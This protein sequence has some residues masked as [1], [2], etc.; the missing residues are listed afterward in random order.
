MARILQVQLQRIRHLSRTSLQ[1]RVVGSVFTTSLVMIVGLGLV[2]VWFVSQQ[3]IDTK[4]QIASNEIERAR[5][6]VEQQVEATDSS[7]SLQVR[8]NSARAALT[9]KTSSSTTGEAAAVY[10]PVVQVTNTD[11]SVV[12]SPEGYRIPETLR[13]V[14]AQQQV[15]Y[16]FTTVTRNDG[17]L[18][19]SLI[20]GSPT[21][22]DI[23]GLEVYLVLPLENEESTLSLI[24][25]LLAVGGLL[26]VGLLLAITFLLTRQIIQP[27]RS[28]SRIA[29]RLTAGHRKERMQVKGEDEMATLARSFNT[30]AESL[31]QQI[32]QLEEYGDLQRQFTSDVSHELRTPLTTVRMAADVIADNREELDP[33]TARASEL[34]IRE[35]DRFEALLGDLLEISRHDAGV[36]DLNEEQVDITTAIVSAFSQVQHL[37]KELG[38]PVYFALPSTPTVVRCDI[39]RIERIL[40]NL[41]AN[42][43]DQSEGHPILVR[44]AANDQAA[45]ITVSDNGVGLKPGQEALVFNRFWRADASRVRHSGG[46]GLGLSIA[47]N[48]ALL[49]G[50]TLDAKG[51]IGVGSTFRLIVPR[52]PAGHVDRD[53]LPLTLLP[54]F[55]DD[56]VEHYREGLE[57]GLLTTD[58]SW[59]I[60][61]Y[62][63][64]TGNPAL[65]AGTIAGQ[66]ADVTEDLQLDNQP[67]SAANTIADE[68][69]QL[70][71]A[72]DSNAAA[73][74]ER[75]RTNATAATANSPA[76]GIASTTTTSD[77]VPTTPAAAVVSTAP[78]EVAAPPEP[79][80]QPT[81]HNRGGEDTTQ[82]PVD[83]RQLYE[84][85]PAENSAENQHGYPAAF[86]TPAD[87]AT[88]QSDSGTTARE[89][90]RHI[91]EDEPVTE[92]ELAA[93]DDFDD[94]GDIADAD[95]AD[96]IAERSDQHRSPQQAAEQST[97]ATPPTGDHQ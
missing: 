57:A 3:L 61:N 87:L 6:T 88:P 29:Q 76:E 7:N 15:A 38:V 77:T 42:A 20:I 39:R 97:P 43:I 30:M 48:D 31:S 11:G 70:I 92:E 37:A 83:H 12:A 9:N 68:A 60:R 62:G 67:P 5:I 84:Q 95:D 50:G 89:A 59:R 16:Q 4:L 1:W 96:I 91:P 90:M 63:D 33:I 21:Q 18:A 13:E 74:A 47:H 69:E 40:R 17:S 71:D 56:S 41:L 32:Q 65:T 26:L 19:R 36:A 73:H 25:R 51:E 79:P 23:P 72:A 55:T 78:V 53:P 52:E 8:L 94:F 64:T 27:V 46:T 93:F 10:E 28:A 66:D 80:S 54:S 49:H 82:T 81:S 58:P 75:S 34:M 22:S 86:P 2:L 35:L 14:V 24:R 85:S 44:L 45:G